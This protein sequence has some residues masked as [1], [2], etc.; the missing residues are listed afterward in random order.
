MKPPSSPHHSDGEDL[1]FGI[2]DFLES[3][4]CAPSVL[5]Y[6]DTVL[7]GGVTGALEFPSL[8]DWSV[9][10]DHPLDMPLIPPKAARTWKRGDEQIFWGRPCKYPLGISSVD[11][12]LIEFSYRP[13]IYGAHLLNGDCCSLNISSSSQN[14]AARRMCAC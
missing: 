13:T 1:L 14:K 11:R 4:V 12:V 2:V 7:I 3:V 6:R 8:P 9:K 10:P 5:G